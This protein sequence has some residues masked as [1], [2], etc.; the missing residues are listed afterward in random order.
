[1]TILKCNY[2]DR[3]YKNS[4]PF[5]RHIAVCKFIQYSSK[6]RTL[7]TEYIEKTTHHMLL[8]R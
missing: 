5:T 8:C 3:Q 1:M 6:E 7:T 2:C 4:M